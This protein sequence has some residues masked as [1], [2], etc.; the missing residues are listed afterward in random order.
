[1]SVRTG[2]IILL[3]CCFWTSAAFAQGYG[4]LGSSAEGFDVP[5]RG[6][7]ITFPKDHGAHP[8]FRIEWWYLTA[9][10]KSGL[11]LALLGKI[12]SIRKL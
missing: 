12:W 1:M 3:I 9:N 11:V 8:G 10:L 5:Q 6:E 7:T 4:G 2:F